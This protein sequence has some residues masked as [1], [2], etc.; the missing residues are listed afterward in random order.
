MLG[1]HRKPIRIGEELGFLFSPAFG[2]IE[3]GEFTVVII[4]RIIRLK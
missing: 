3:N 2:D 1:N 4:F